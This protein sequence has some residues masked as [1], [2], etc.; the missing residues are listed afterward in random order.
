MRKALSAVVAT[1]IA[2]AG[3]TAVADSAAASHSKTR[4]DYVAL[5]DS[6]ASGVG[7][8][9]YD[10]AS[11]ACLQ[12]PKSYPRSWSRKHPKLKLKDETCSGYRVPQV[13]AE[14]LDALSRK[15]KL[16]TLTVGG[17][18]VGFRTTVDACLGGTDAQCQGAAA[19]AVNYANTTLIGDLTTLYGEIRAKAPNAR[20][21]VLG[22]PHLVD[23]DGTGSCGDITPN[24][25]R[26]ALF[27]TTVDA[28]N[29]AIVTA[30]KQARVKFIDMR[31]TFD[32]HEACSED[33]WLHEV[34]LDNTSE[35][36]HPTDAGYRAYTR[37][38]TKAIG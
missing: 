14:Q 24:A 8:S 25:E 23:P 38:L 30:T 35:M 19:L 20:L 28:V 21:V 36:F 26:R 9:V 34:D 17:N 5:G 32:G 2:F 33:P 15:T 22:Y 13:R 11:G 27:T 12:S 37:Q 1:V 16:V 3:A 7:A 4:G 31:K 18:D 29:E 10:E 6:Y